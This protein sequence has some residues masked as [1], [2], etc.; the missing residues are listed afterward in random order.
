MCSCSGYCSPPGHG[1][2]FWRCNSAYRIDVALH[3]HI[4]EVITF[5]CFILHLYTP[6]HVSKKIGLHIPLPQG[7]IIEPDFQQQVYDCLNGGPVEGAANVLGNMNDLFLKSLVETVAQT[8]LGC[9]LDA[10]IKTPIS[11]ADFAPG[12]DPLLLIKS[13][14]VAKWV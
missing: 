4:I 11:T 1:A 14:Q 9:Y 12:H 8:I 7:A 5:S 6:F 13:R 3:Q 2:C 10:M